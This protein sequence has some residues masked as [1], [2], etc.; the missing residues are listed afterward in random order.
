MVR[1]PD[2]NRWRPY[3]AS[4]LLSVQYRFGTQRGWLPP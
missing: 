1:I 4:N 2:G 3:L